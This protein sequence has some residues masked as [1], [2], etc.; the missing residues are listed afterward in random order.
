MS[1][2]MCRC[3][4]CEIVMIYQIHDDRMA[5]KLCAPI[6]APSQKVMFKLPSEQEG[7]SRAA[8][9]WTMA[10]E[11]VMSAAGSETRS[12]AEKEERE[13]GSDS[14]NDSDGDAESESDSGSDSGSESNTDERGNSSGNESDEE[15]S[16]VGEEGSDTEHGSTGDEMAAL[17]PLLLRG[18]SVQTEASFSTLLLVSACSFAT[19]ECGCGC[20]G[21]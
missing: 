2:H 20:C 4:C 18:G 13:E 11:A 21:W 17:K 9:E 12:A 16:D 14:V 8:G 19:C 15:R 7:Q 6:C 5:F 1:V 3:I 10:S